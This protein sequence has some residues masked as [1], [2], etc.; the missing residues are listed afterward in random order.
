MPKAGER[1]KCMCEMRHQIPE[2]KAFQLTWQW[3]ADSCGG[4]FGG[5][6]YLVDQ[7]GHAYTS[8]REPRAPS[9]VLA[10]E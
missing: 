2:E 9:L 5:R 10:P 1:L 4:V 3:L 7:S 6:G 8:G